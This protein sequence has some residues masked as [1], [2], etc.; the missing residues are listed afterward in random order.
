MSS[1]LD[2][3]EDWAGIAR[4]AGY[5]V[6]IMASQCRVSQRQLERYFLISKQK[7]PHLWLRE[8]RLKR[9]V[10][11]LRNDMDLKVVAAQLCYK[12]ASHFH[13]DFKAYFGVTPGRFAWQGVGSSLGGYPVAFS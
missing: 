9:A 13:H 5:S 8:L 6:T 3:V 1:R 4:A 10:E 2:R 7:S 11:L 12:T